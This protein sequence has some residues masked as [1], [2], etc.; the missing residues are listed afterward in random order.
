MWRFVFLYA[1]YFFFKKEINKQFEEV[2][3]AHEVYWIDLNGE[4]I[5]L[6]SIKDIEENKYDF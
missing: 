3:A 4:Q 1:S 6:S 2:L 5:R